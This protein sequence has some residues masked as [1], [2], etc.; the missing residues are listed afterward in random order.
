MAPSAMPGTI[1]RVVEGSLLRVLEHL[2]EEGF[3]VPH[4]VDEDDVWAVLGHVTHIAGDIAAHLFGG[5]DGSQSGTFPALDPEVDAGIGLGQGSFLV[6]GDVDPL[7]GGGQD[8]VGEGSAL[9]AIE[10][11]KEVGG[12]VAGYVGDMTENSQTSSW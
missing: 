8:R 1:P 9:G 10:A 3:K 12:Y 6:L 5:F 4:E 2:G 7:A 11:A